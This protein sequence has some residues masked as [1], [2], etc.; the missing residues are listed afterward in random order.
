MVEPLSDLRTWLHQTISAKAIANTV[1]ET[2]FS[3]KPVA[4]EVILS[5]TYQTSTAAVRRRHSEHA[6]GLSKRCNTDVTASNVNPQPSVT[7]PISATAKRNG[8]SIDE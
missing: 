5:T 7:A 4:I 2:A 3:A 6:T 8:A 1:F